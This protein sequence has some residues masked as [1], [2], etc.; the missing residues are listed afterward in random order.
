MQDT[1]YGFCHCGC[2][3]KTRIAPQS[4]TKLGWVKGE[5]IRYIGGHN[6]RSSPV[7]YLEQDTGYD[8][9]CW[10]WQRSL[11]DRGYGYLRHQGQCRLAHRVYW[12]EAN[13]PVPPGMQLDHLCR[14]PACVNPDHLQPVSNAENTRRGNMAKLTYEKVAEIRVLLAQG[15]PQRTIAEQY[16]VACPQISRINTGWN[17]RWQ[18]DRVDLPDSA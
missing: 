8:T 3:E 11:N 16:G 4:H 5:P 12:T 17:G 6:T 13:G 18:K 7:A 14:K 1:P 10:I 2:G 9:P 15:V